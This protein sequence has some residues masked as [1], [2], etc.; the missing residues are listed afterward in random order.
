M[1]SKAIFAG[2]FDPFTIGHE[3]VVRTALQLVDEVIVGV[4]VN[5]DKKTLFSP[6]E[7]VAIIK[8]VFPDPRVS[9]KT[10][11]GLVVNF[12]KQEQ[13]KILVRGLRTESDFSYE[14]P[15]AMTNRQLMPEVMTIFF[16]TSHESQYISSSLVREVAAFGGDVTPFVP[17]AALPWLKAKFRKS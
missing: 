3:E 2:S 13:V 1:K 5:L 11:N 16:P 4:G 6:E 12:A 17:A 9:V 8:A 7:R 14:M 10:F 15:M